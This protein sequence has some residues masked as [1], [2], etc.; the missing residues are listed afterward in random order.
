MNKILPIILVVLF[1]STVGA[2]PLSSDDAKLLLKEKY[3]KELHEWI[4]D[5]KADNGQINFSMKVIQERVQRPCSSLV[6]LLATQDEV[7]SFITRE[8]I[9][10]Y[11]FRWQFCMSAVIENVAPGQPGFSDKVM[12]GAC[13]EDLSILT[14]VCTEFIK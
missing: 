9:N 13:Q 11:D 12:A 6:M 7:N 4:N 5:A 3:V 2:D 1:S 10:E 14:L 8:D